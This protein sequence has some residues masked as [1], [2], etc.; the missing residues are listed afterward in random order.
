LSAPLR[1]GQHDAGAPFLLTEFPQAGLNVSPPLDHLQIGAQPAQLPGPPDAAGSHPGALRQAREA[2]RLFGK[3][4]ISRRGTFENRDQFKVEGELGEIDTADSEIV[5][6]GIRMPFI[7][8]A[9]IGTLGDRASDD[10]L[11]LFKADDQKGVPFT[12]QATESLFLGGS[13]S[14]DYTQ[15]DEYDLDKTNERDQQQCDPEQVFAI[16]APDPVFLD[17][18]AKR[19]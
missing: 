18:G 14:F 17:V 2:T 10:P 3:Q 19:L 1:A 15:E 9:S 4:H 13:G 5:V 7:P 12:I 11:A 16:G 8:G 6:G